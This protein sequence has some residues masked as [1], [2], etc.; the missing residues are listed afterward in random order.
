[1]NIIKKHS[2]LSLI[3]LALL[4]GI[5]WRIEI[6]YHGWK[7]LIWLS[8]FH[9]AIPIGFGLFLLWAN[10]CIELKMNKRIQ[11]NIT[12]ILFGIFIYFW[13]KIS[14][15][16]L[17]NPGSSA[18]ILEMQTPRWIFFVFRYSIFILIP[19][20]P[21]GTYTI[22]NIFK[23]KRPIKQLF[24][25]ILSILIAVPI[26]VILLKI[27]NH[28]GAHNYIHSIKSGYIIPLIVISIGLMLIKKKSTKSMR[29]L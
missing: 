24:Y 5:I 3:L 21:I 22:L 17:F 2:Y 19:L 26:S 25:A 11:L 12:A 1:M 20:L 23:I 28:K 10:L 13:L 9:I 6:E 16:Y 27:S 15:Y 14:L 7:G 18:L 29:S 8:Y 4:C